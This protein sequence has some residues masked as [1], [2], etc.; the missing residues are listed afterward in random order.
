MYVICWLL[1]LIRCKEREERKTF[2]LVKYIIGTSSYLSHSF[3]YRK[4]NRKKSTQKIYKYMDVYSFCVR[5]KVC[6]IHSLNKVPKRIQQQQH[7]ITFFF[8]VTELRLKSWSMGKL[9]RIAYMFCCVNTFFSWCHLFVYLF[10]YLS[11]TKCG[12]TKN[13]R[14]YICQALFTSRADLLC[15]HSYAH[16]HAHDNGIN[17]TRLRA[18]HRIE[19][20]WILP[21]IYMTN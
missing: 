5:V 12:H 2:K 9:Y 20:H 6:P 10:I 21:G 1:T 4:R 11:H 17:V 19:E 16:H 15:K 7:N 8:I 18:T 3:S 14:F 13:G